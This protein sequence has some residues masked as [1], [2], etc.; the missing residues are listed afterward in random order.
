MTTVQPSALARRLTELSRAVVA[1]AGL[2]EQVAG[3]L[4]QLVHV[5]GWLVLLSGS[6]SLLIHQ[7]LSLAH[8][9]TP[10]AGALAVLQSLIRSRRQE[11]SDRSAV[12]SDEVPGAGLSDITC[13]DDQASVLEQGESDG[14]I[15]QG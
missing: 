7:H 4:R 5:V 3:L 2:L 9:M 1:V 10:A 14:P 8:L 15:C 6:F 11:G 12:L 13:L